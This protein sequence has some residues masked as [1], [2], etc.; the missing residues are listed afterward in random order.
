[1]ARC[2]ERNLRGQGHGLERVPFPPQLHSETYLHP[3]DPSPAWH[4]PVSTGSPNFMLLT[5]EIAFQPLAEAASFRRPHP[6]GDVPP[7]GA[8]NLLSLPFP[9]KLWRLVSSNQFSS[10]WWDDSGTCIVINQKLFEKEILKRDVAHKVFATNSIKSFFHQLNLHGFRKWRQCTFRTFTR[11]FSTNRPVSISNKLEF[12]CHPYFQRDS[13]HLLVRMKRRVGVKSA[14]RHQEEDKPEA[15][16]SCLAPADTEQQDHTSP[17]ENDQVTLQHQEPAGPN[18]QIRSG[19]APPATPVMVPNPAMASDN[20]PA[21][22]P[23]GEWSEG[24]QAHVTPVATVPGPAALPFL[25]V[26]GYPTQMNSYGPVVALPTASPSALAMDT[27]GLPAP[28]MLPF[29]HLWVPVTL[30]AAGAAQPAASMAM[31]PHPPALH[32]HCPHSHRMSRYMPASDG[33]RRTQPMQTRA[34]RGEHLGRIR[35]GQ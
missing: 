10:I 13:P 18:T 22:Q 12:Y 11:I 6:D 29:C 8:D 1:M 31:F 5:E 32:H 35:A 9:Q 3:A 34:H 33:P 24:S 19:S 23:A 21:T 16:G 25:Y 7:Q 27:T 15:A 2:E 17:N 28:G 26:P 20:A 30:V 14:P 4:D